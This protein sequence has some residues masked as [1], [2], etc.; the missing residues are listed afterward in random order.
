MF[1]VEKPLL[2]KSNLLDARFKDFPLR[3]TLH[4]Q[5]INTLSTSTRSF[6]P[7]IITAVSQLS[8][9]PIP[10]CSRILRSLNDKTISLRDHEA[11]RTKPGNCWHVGETTHLFFPPP[12]AL[13]ESS[14]VT[15]RLSQ[16]HQASAYSSPGRIRR[17]KSLSAWFKTLSIRASLHAQM[18]MQMEER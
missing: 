6:L 7:L 10:R 11:R 4:K 18:E 13:C 14:N 1:W 15:E 8:V 17:K 5:T 3:P 2:F 16:H 9:Q 12:A